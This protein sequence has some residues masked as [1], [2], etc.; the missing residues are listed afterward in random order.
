MSTRSFVDNSIS[1]MVLNINYHRDNGCI[2]ELNIKW[3]KPCKHP[4]YIV[5]KLTNLTETLDLSNDKLNHKNK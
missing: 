4:K 1:K 5:L 3:S 2:K